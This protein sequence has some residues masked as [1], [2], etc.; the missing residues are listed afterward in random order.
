MP[1]LSEAQELKVT[2]SPD[3]NKINREVSGGTSTIVFE[4]GVKDLSISNDMRDECLQITND[5]TVFLIQP[6]SEECVRELGYP[7]RTYILKT[8]KT[9]EYLLQLNEIMPSNV[10]Y[11][12]VTMPN[13]YPLSF[14]AEYLFSQSTSYGIR[15]SYGKQIGGY[16]SYRWG[17]YKPSGNSIDEI[18]IDGDVS[19]AKCLGYIREAI[20][21]G[22]RVGILYNDILNRRIGVYLLVGGGYGEYGRQWQN[23]TQLDGNIYFYSDYIKGF[24]GDAAIQ[25]T[26]GNWIVASVGADAILSKGR[27]S[28][29]YQLGVGI[30]LNF[31]KLFKRKAQ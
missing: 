4:S 14:T 29:D 7:K 1:Y 9:P 13:R 15:L 26:I 27:T 12:T 23:P 25:C 20:T 16:F 11:Y 28:I 19:N 17:E 8:P 10:Y 2:R 5:M 31:T 21:G 30:N 3:G 24:N 18:S 22:V 6:E